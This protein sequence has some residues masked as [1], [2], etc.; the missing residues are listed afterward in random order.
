MK[1]ILVFLLAMFSLPSFLVDASCK[2]GCCEDRM[3]LVSF[4]GRDLEPRFFLDQKIFKVRVGRS[5]YFNPGRE[6]LALLKDSVGNYYIF[7]EGD[8]TRAY[9]RNEFE[10]IEE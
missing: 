4:G 10:Q 7:V 2:E 9:D 6:G 1:S 8:G 3:R 5:A